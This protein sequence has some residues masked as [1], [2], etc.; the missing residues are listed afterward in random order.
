MPKIYGKKVLL[1][2]KFNIAIIFM[3]NAKNLLQKST[4]RKK[5]K[6]P[7]S[8]V[9]IAGNLLQKSTLSRAIQNP[10]HFCDKCQK[11]TVLLGG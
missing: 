2:G 5:F 7:I 11:I 10:Y 1:G 3:T 6:I 4:C 8:F 9:T